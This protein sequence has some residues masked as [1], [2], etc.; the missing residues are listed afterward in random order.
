MLR[1]S[2]ARPRRPRGRGPRATA[3]SPITKPRAPAPEGFAERAARHA[4]EDAEKARRDDEARRRGRVEWAARDVVAVATGDQPLYTQ[5]KLDIDRQ[6]L[7][8][9][10]SGTTQKELYEDQYDWQ[11]ER[12]AFWSK[13]R[14]CA[15][16]MTSTETLTAIAALE[17]E[18]DAALAAVRAA[19]VDEALGPLLRRQL[20]RVHRNFAERVAVLMPEPMLLAGTRHWKALTLFPELCMSARAAHAFVDPGA[21]LPECKLAIETGLHALCAKHPSLCCASAALATAWIAY[22]V[23][24]QQLVHETPA[25]RLAR[26][27]NKAA[28]SSAL[29]KHLEANA[30]DAAALP[31]DAVA[32][33]VGALVPP[34]SQP[35]RHPPHKRHAVFVL[36]L[37]ATLPVALLEAHADTIDRLVATSTDPQ[38]V[39][40]LDRLV[41]HLYDPKTMNMEREKAQAMMVLV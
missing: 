9:P 19:S 5:M 26:C 30:A 4:R 34:Q 7:D 36:R 8:R 10:A 29:V 24:D 16:R 41:R 2:R 17:G 3:R 32:V 39:H 11:A 14:G 40:L 20:N 27:F 6:A 18:R 12:Y 23:H 33:A 35:Q 1:L 37:L 31:A 21:T 25:E 22:L 13:V 28:P 15:E 38:L